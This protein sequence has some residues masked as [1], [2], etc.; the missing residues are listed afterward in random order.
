VLPGGGGKIRPAPPVFLMTPAF[1]FTFGIETT[2]SALS[3][4]TIILGLLVVAIA[5]AL[6]AI[7]GLRRRVEDLS[8]PRVPAPTSSAPAA[9]P[10]P[11]PARDELTPELIAVIAAAVRVTLGDTRHRIVSLSSA[12]QIHGDNRSAWSVEGRRQVFQSHVVR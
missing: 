9:S 1:L 5:Y 12:N 4:Q 10:K 2:P 6:V 11:T 3:P 8:A 7:A